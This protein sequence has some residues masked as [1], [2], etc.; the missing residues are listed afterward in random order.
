MSL[1]I[2]TSSVFSVTLYNV[3]RLL[4]ICLPVNIYI[5]GTLH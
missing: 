3:L 5:G 4:Q 1:C 2:D